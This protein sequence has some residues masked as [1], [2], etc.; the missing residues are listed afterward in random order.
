MEDRWVDSP[1]ERREQMNKFQ[2]GGDRPGDTHLFL[3]STRAGGL[4]RG[5][6]LTAADTIMFYDQGWVGFCLFLVGVIRV[7]RSYV[8]ASSDRHTSA[9]SSP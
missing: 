7:D 9:G 3:F 8:I 1:L 6:N 4:A 5:I 2:N